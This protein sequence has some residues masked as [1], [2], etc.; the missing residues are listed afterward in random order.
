MG[1]CPYETI[2]EAQ[3]RGRAERA[4]Q[5]LRSMRTTLDYLR[6]DLGKMTRRRDKALDL[7]EA[8]GALLDDFS[9]EKKVLVAERNRAQEALAT[10]TAARDAVSKTLH[11]T[12]KGHK[13]KTEQRD[14]FQWLLERERL[15][16]ANTTAC[17]KTVTKQRDQ[18]QEDYKRAKR[19]VEELYGEIYQARTDLKGKSL[20]LAQSVK[21]FFNACKHAQDAERYT[22]TLIKTLDDEVKAHQVSLAER[23]KARAL[24]KGDHEERITTLEVLA[25]VPNNKSKG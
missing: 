4:E 5:E 7:Y 15:N 19:T 10:M 2:N 12:R 22:K 18:A 23:D 8:R 25:G 24:T 6:D 20:A 16:H 1:T 3:Q 21:E 14:Q 9:R 13:A 11:G 17:F